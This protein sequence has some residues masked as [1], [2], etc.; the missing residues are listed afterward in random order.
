MTLFTYLLEKLALSLKHVH[1]S[2]QDK[3][4]SVQLFVRSYE[5]L[6]V[7]FFGSKTGWNGDVLPKTIVLILI[8]QRGYFLSVFF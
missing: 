8:K 3:R 4:M 6:A 7:S 5:T 1:I 2:I